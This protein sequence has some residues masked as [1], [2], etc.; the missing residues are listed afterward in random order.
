M[1][2]VIA[3]V[4]RPNVGKSTL[5]N[6]LTRSRDALVADQP[7]LTRDRKYGEGRVG[8]YPYLVVDTGGLSGDKEGI[9]ELMADQVWLAVEEADVVLFMVDA[10]D[11]L[12]AGD[13]EIAKRLRTVGK[14]VHLVVNKIDGADLQVVIAEFYNLGLGEPL[15]ITAS[16]RGGVN[17]LMAEVLPKLDESEIEEE[18]EDLGIKIAI[19][20]K[21]NVGK[22]TLINRILGEERVLAYD[23]PGTTRDSI[24]TPRATLHLY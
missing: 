20:G 5:F 10:R 4:G 23:M 21:P 14:K 8:D 16:Q 13:Q 1:K 18:E 3:L 9:D 11:G 6:C 7:G 19:V 2:P 17:D 12:V 22:S 24:R 15:G